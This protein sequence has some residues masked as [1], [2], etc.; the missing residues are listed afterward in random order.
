MRFEARGAEYQ[1]SKRFSGQTGT[2]RLTQM[3]GQT[4]QGEE[5]ET[6]LA[7][8]LGVDEVG[9]GKGV[10]ERVKKQ[11]AHLWVWQGESGDDLSESV[12][13]QQAGLLRRLQQVGGAVAMQS[14]LDDRVASRFSQARGL[15]YG[16]SAGGTALK[17]SELGQAQ[18]DVQ[19]AEAA[20]D[21]A[22]ERVDRLRQAMEANE[23]AALAIKRAV[24]A[25]EGITSERQEVEQKLAEVAQ[26]RRSEETQAQAVATA[27]ERV[28]AL[29][30]V[31]NNLAG[32]RE[33]MSAAQ[34]AVEPLEEKQRLLE[35]RLAEARDGLGESQQA[36]D[37]CLGE[38][39]RGP[40]QSWAC[41]G[42][43]HA[44]QEAGAQPGAERPPGARAG[45]AEGAGRH[46]GAVGPSGGHR[47]I[48]PGGVAGPE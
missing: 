8:L 5:A 16:K 34:Q 6:R 29:E 40:T 4:W 18:A 32:L 14:E 43:R 35:S 3:G 15:I 48:R 23:Q 11:W 41:R 42:V 28:A 30:G 2:V 33:A 36:Y 38:S 26:L 13:A 44:V 19:Q 31:E 24:S 1:L 39:P 12:E 17:N 37:R 20:R 25:L 27:V 21:A 47:P 9:G 22:A 7:R 10:L 46:P 45:P